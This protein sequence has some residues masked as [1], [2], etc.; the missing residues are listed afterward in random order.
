MGP[1][2]G[3]IPPGWWRPTRPCGPQPWSRQPEGWRHGQGVLAGRGLAAW[4]AT[5]AAVVS[6]PAA[7]TPAPEHCD[8]PTPIQS[9]PPD[10]DAP[11]PPLSSLP[12][13]GQIVAV[14]AQMALAHL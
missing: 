11:V 4:T 8:P 2:A 10:H 3:A 5:C 13:A 12:D 6:A 9:R 14:L 1:S 7:G